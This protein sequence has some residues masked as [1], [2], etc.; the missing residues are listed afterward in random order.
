METPNWSTVT[1]NELWRYVAWHLEGAGI[2]SVLVGGAVVSIY[3]KGIY[4]SGDLD[5]VPDDFQRPKIAEV[6]KSI[7]FFSKKSRHFKHPECDHLV[8]EFPHG[9][10][11]VGEQY[12]VIPDEIIVNGRTLRLL[13]PTDCVKD[14]LA[15][16][17]H[18]N[19]GD[20]FDQA[21][22]VCRVQKDRVDLQN[23]A[24]WCEKEGGANAYV[25]LAKRLS[26]PA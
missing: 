16:Y 2:R 1:E 10:V 23:V 4:R 19:A 15:A 20:C 24:D 26:T 14:R 18:W 17:I 11:E 25:R 5:I 12:P 22:L 9:P 21:V 3:T 13:S 6:L 7:G 8:V